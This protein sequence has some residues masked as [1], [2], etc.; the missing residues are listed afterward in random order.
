MQLKSNQTESNV[1]NIEEREEEEE[2]DEE[3]LYDG[4]EDEQE[5]DWWGVRGSGVACKGLSGDG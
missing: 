4:E 5:E 3:E 1:N 2:Y